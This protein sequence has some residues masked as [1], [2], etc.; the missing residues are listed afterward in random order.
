M[1][2][3][4][5]LKIFHSNFLVFKEIKYVDRYKKAQLVYRSYLTDSQRIGLYIFISALAV[6]IICLSFSDHDN[7]RFSV[8]SEEDKPASDALSK[9]FYIQ[10][11]V[12]F[13]LI[14]PLL[15]KIK[16]QNIDPEKP[17]WMMSIQNWYAP[18][19]T[20][21]V[22]SPESIAKPADSGHTI[23]IEATLDTLTLGFGSVKAAINELNQ[24]MKDQSTYTQ[25]KP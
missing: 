8:H 11:L 21:R 14:V 23:K 2:S 5:R 6:V 9:S 12:I 3:L 18:E 24:T 10:A 17:Y 7:Q 19:Y 1:D 15:K 22:V 4:V 25:T 16:P 13:I 20:A